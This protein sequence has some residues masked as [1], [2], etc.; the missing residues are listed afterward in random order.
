MFESELVHKD[1]V[2]ESE[3]ESK[4]NIYTSIFYSHSDPNRLQS[5]LNEELSNFDVWLKCN[6]LSLVN[7]KKNNYIFFK[8]RQGT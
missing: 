4:C 5:I 8:S 2:S 6:K 7:L 3:L 1:V